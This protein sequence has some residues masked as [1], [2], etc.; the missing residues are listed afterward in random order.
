MVQQTN[1]CDNSDDKFGTACGV[2]FVGVGDRYAFQVDFQSI[3][4]N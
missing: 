3:V 4:V 2:I 1:V